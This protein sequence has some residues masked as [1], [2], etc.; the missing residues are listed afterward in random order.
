[1]MPS[2]L[3][4]RVDKAMQAFVDEIQAC[5]KIN[6][7]FHEMDKYPWMDTLE[8]EIVPEIEHILNYDPTPQ[9]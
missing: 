1:M 6:D 2:E 9:Y 3:D 5:V 4:K 8:H 7:R